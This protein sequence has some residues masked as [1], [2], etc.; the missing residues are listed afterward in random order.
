MSSIRAGQTPTVNIY[1]CHDPLFLNVSLL[2]F[3]DFNK[4]EN[5]K[6]N[7]VCGIIENIS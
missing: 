1:L 3:A 5:V 7:T 2:L 6:L 4:N